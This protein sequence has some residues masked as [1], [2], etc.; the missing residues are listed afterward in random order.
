MCAQPASRSVTAIS[1]DARPMSSHT[2]AIS[3]TFSELTCINS[4]LLM[5]I[6]EAVNDEAVR[7]K[8]V[9]SEGNRIASKPVNRQEEFHLKMVG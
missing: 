8:P 4:A 2:A 3:A 6:A 1:A 7:T 5:R 9:M